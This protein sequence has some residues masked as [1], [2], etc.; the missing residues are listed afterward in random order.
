MSLSPT[1]MNVQ[2]ASTVLDK[3]EKG[4]VSCHDIHEQLR[5]IRDIIGLSEMQYSEVYKILLKKYE[6]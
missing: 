6:V 3:K 2:L 5:H 4:T 1:E